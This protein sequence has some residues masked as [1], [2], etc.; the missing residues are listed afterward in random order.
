MPAAGAARPSTAPDRP[1]HDLVE[2][3]PCPSV[4]GLLLVGHGSESVE[5]AGSG[6]LSHAERIVA[7][8]AFGAVAAGF[9][10]GRPTVEE[11]LASLGSGPLYVVP[12]FMGEG[13]FTTVAIP[14]R[15][16]LAAAG[17][18][19]GGRKLHLCPPVGCNPD[20]AAVLASRAERACGARGLDAASATLLLVGHGN[21]ESSE[22]S[23]MLRRHAERLAR[24]GRFAAVEVAFLEEEPLLGSVLAR[25]GVRDVVAIGVLAGEG[26]HTVEDIPALVAAEQARRREAGQTATLVYTGVIGPDPDMVQLILG[27][28]RA[29]DRNRPGKAV[30]APC[31]SDLP[32]GPGARGRAG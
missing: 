12:Y 32:V 13:Y 23:Q 16:G 26:K 2:T 30:T 5:D 18:G 20:L 3:A 27:Q 14:R 22:S 10:N 4:A 25:T 8:G 31:P 15:L 29:F 21:P 1:G 19:E 7:A 6:L 17:N 24:E 11:A 28:V 9:L